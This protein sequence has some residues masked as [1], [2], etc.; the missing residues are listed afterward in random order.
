MSTFLLQSP[1]LI[2][3]KMIDVDASSIHYLIE[4]GADIHHKDEYG[5]TALHHA[6]LRGD[7]IGCQQLLLYATEEEPLVN[8]SLTPFYSTLHYYSSYEYM[9][10]SSMAFTKA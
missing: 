3:G 7:E 2:G 5:L 10:V 6:A 9:C 1:S 4:H 8:V